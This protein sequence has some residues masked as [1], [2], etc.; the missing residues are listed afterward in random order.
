ME[1]RYP[2]THSLTRSPTRSL[3]SER[4]WRGC[5]CSIIPPTRFV[6]GGKKRGKKGTKADI[7][8]FCQDHVDV[9][10]VFVLSCLLFLQIFLFL[11]LFFYYLNSIYVSLIF[12]E[13]GGVWVY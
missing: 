3:A 1:A 5:V 11:F 2:L 10:I 4:A 9:M 12:F 7:C 13:R 6:N 8:R